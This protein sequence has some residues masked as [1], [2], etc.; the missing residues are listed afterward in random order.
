MAEDVTLGPR[1]QS[2]IALVKKQISTVARWAEFAVL[3][4]C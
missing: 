2:F 4:I 3:L 1:G